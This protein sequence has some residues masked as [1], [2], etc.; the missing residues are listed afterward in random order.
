MSRA[1]TKWHTRTTTNSTLCG[2]DISLWCVST[3]NH[4]VSSIIYWRNSKFVSFLAEIYNFKVCT[5]FQLCN[6]Y[7]ILF[8]HLV[9]VLDW[10]VD[11]AYAWTPLRIVLGLRPNLGNFASWS[12]APSTSPLNSHGRVEVPNRLWQSLTLPFLFGLIPYLTWN[13]LVSL[14]KYM[15]SFKK[16][17][18]F[19]PFFFVLSKNLLPLNI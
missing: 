1:F 8:G 9:H 4:L 11:G 13:F 14:P 2:P 16:A 3:R 18:Q 7:F 10:S 12:K 17:K 15:H 5:I 19:L 6:M